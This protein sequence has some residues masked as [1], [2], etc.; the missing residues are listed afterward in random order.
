MADSQ[1]LRYPDVQKETV[2]GDVGVGVPHLL[3]LK[4]REVF[5]TLLVAGVG[6]LRCVQDAGPGLGGYGFSEAQGADG[7]LGKR[8]ARKHV[9]LAA[10][11]V[12]T[13]PAH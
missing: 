11:H 1:P 8:D 6:Q 13:E 3:A 5:V 4:P 12:L 9:D 7:W 2:L 10:K